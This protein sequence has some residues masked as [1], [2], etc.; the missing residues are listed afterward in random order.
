MTGSN[1]LLEAGGKRILIDCGL[2]QGIGFCDEINCDPFPYDAKKIDALFV[3][4]AHIDH[5]GRIPKLVQS[6]FKGKIYSTPPTRDMAELLLL[7]SEHI[8]SKEM[9]RLGLP[10]LYGAE[11]V[12]RALDLWEGIPYHEPVILGDAS[13]TLYNSGHVLGSSFILIEAEGKKI[14]FSGDLG[15]FP[16]PI[17][18]PTEFIKDADYVLIEST[19]G[20]RVHE[21]LPKRKE[22]LQKVIEASIKAHGAL[23]IPAFAMERTQELLYE[24]NEL[25]EKK[26]VPR[27][28]IYLD[29]PLAIKL[30]AVYKKYESYFNT[31]AK[32]LIESG[33]KI[34]N[35]PGLKSTLTTEESKAIN[36]VPNPKIIIAGSG[37][38]QGG[39]IMHHAARYLKDPKSAILFI[40]YQAAGSLGRRLYEGSKNNDMSAR[41][42]FSVKIFG[43]EIPVEAKIEAIGGYSAHADQPRLLAWLAPMA[44][45]LKKIFVCIGEEDQGEA[46]AQKI[47]EKFGVRAEIPNIGDVME[48]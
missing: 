15:N 40:G 26:L 16:A 11:E 18:Q 19:Y 27:V 47:K 44:K 1:F 17:I 42:P 38:L 13:I 37:M 12:F 46:L 36:N 2:R 30:T 23:L 20:G 31:E 22:K 3:T 29:S 28:P 43:E 25:V 4:H 6:G 34:F 35:F 10:P 14:V 33:D 48:L 41:S 32:R 21:S 7:D 5:T 45:N 9:E 8:I 39:R 24:L